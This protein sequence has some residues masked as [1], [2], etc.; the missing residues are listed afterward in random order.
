MKIAL[1]TLGRKS[2]IKSLV[3]ISKFRTRIVNEV[4]F[5][6]V[7]DSANIL[8]LAP[9][10][11]AV[12]DVVIIREDTCTLV[13]TKWPIILFFVYSLHVRPLV[14]AGGMFRL[15]MVIIIDS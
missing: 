1:F 15:V 8:Q 9:Y 5:T 11:K 3:K 14:L 6:C 4:Q 7:V 10:P 12:G 13:P 2:R